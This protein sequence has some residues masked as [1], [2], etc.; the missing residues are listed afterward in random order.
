MKESAVKVASPGSQLVKLRW[1][2]TNKAERRAH[3]LKMVAARRAK[4]KKR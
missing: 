3:A 2:K 4:R 1:D